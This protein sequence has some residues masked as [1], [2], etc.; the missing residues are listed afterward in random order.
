M[1]ALPAACLIP[2]HYLLRAPAPSH[3]A[4]SPILLELLDPELGEGECNTLDV[5][6]VLQN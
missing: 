3:Y 1:L 2:P 4:H 6:H 5:H